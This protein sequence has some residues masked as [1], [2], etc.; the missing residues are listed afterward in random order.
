MSPAIEH[1]DAEIARLQAEIASVERA[2]PTVAERFAD[3]EAELRDAERLYRTRGLKVSA[4]HPDQTAFLQRQALLGACMVVGADQLLRAERQRIE[5]AGRRPV[6]ARHGRGGSTSFVDRSCA[7]QPSVSS[8]CGRSRATT[9]S[10]RGRFIPKW[11][12]S[13]AVKSSD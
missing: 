4:A 1:L 6:G 12:Y 10:S 9:N 7:P 13:N 5:A 8:P 2:P 3:V 11:R